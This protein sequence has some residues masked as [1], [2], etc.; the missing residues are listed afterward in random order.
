M[1]KNITRVKVKWCP[2]S[3]DYP[4]IRLDRRKP[5]ES[6]SHVHFDTAEIQLGITSVHMCIT[7][8]V[9]CSVMK[10]RKF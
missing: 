8:A 5:Q 9:A 3:K 6:L 2:I 10:N 4:E 1:I 7:T